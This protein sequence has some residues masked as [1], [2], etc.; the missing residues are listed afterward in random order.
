MDPCAG[1]ER[2]G[3]R[4]GATPKQ[5]DPDS[6]EA[7]HDQLSAK[8]LTSDALEH[9]R[10]GSIL[11]D[12]RAAEEKIR[13]LLR[14][15][16]ALIVLFE[17]GYAIEQRH[18]SVITFNATLSLVLANIAIGIGFFL[19]T[20]IASMPRYWREIGALV[21]IALLVSGSRIGAISMRVEPA[22]VSVCVIVIRA[23]TM[24]PWDWRWQAAISSVG[25]ICFYLLG[26]AHGVVDYDP[27]MHW[28]GLMTAVGLAQ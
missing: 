8:A 24:A 16:G 5:H 13:G 12:S 7:E 10:S 22:F 15:A 26:R 11:S 27:P 6:R 1:R 17:L 23:G 25:M 19:S 4:M 9:A 21:C 18:T 14:S 2:E 28:L 20:F 3:N